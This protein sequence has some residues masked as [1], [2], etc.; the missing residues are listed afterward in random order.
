MKDSGA[1][2]G[3]SIACATTYLEMKW[4]SIPSAIGKKPTD[5]HGVR[6][7]IRAASPRNF[8]TPRAATRGPIALGL[9]LAFRL[10]PSTFAIRKA[11][12]VLQ[13]FVHELGVMNGL[14][15]TAAAGLNSWHGRSVS[16]AVA[17]VA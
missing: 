17:G 15:V 11:A 2:G 6:R 16:R 10:V 4:C 13:L 9:L 1:S 7:N 5:A 3:E 12:S 14:G 8:S